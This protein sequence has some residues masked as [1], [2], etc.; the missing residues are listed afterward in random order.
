MCVPHFEIELLV[1]RLPATFPDRAKAS[2]PSVS[3]LPNGLTVVTEDAAISSTVSMHFPKAG[4]ADE[5]LEEEGA[6]FLNKVLN[7]KSASGISSILLLRTLENEGAT[8]FNDVGRRGGTI[9]F[10]ASPDRAVDLIP[11]LATECDFEPWDV[12]DAKIQAVKEAEYAHQ[13]P[14]IVLTEHLNAAAYG[15]Q[16]PMG[17]PFYSPVA[18]TAAIKSFRSRAY[19]IKGAILTATGIADHSAFV[20]DL[21]QGL[22]D[23]PP[24]DADLPAQPIYLGGES[25]LAV[26]HSG[27][28]HVALAFSSSASAPLRNVVKQFFNLVGS[29]FTGFE[30]QGLVGVYGGSAA[31]DASSLVD[32]ISKAITTKPTADLVKRARLLAKAEALF[33]FEN[34]SKV[35]ATT[36]MAS[37][38]ESG[39]V[40]TASGLAQAY[41]AITEKDVMSEI[42]MLL[43]TNPTLA[44]V[45]DIGLVPYQAALAPRFK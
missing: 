36:L 29:G 40:S 22:E 20:N 21:V 26:P 17:R 10:T 34:G 3:T 24:G 43:K 30:T 15:P 38:K 45:G 35:L 13:T 11:L 42:D 1:D 4:S 28:A 14:E 41:D 37:V 16:S 8:I 32:S 23:S 5:Q 2:T 18:D 44:A 9:G 7:F 31:S 33:G 19:G 6:A 39:T 12:R 25:R 27:Y